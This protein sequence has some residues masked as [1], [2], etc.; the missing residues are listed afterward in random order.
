MKRLARSLVP[1]TT[2]FT[3]V[4]LMAVVAIIG[5]LAMI[6]IPNLANARKKGIE[7]Q[8]MENVASVSV[9]LDRR[10]TDGSFSYTDGAG[11]CP[12][13]ATY[14]GGATVPDLGVTIDGSYFEVDV[15]VADPNGDGLCEAYR[16]TA[17]GVVA[18]VAGE[19][20]SLDHARVKGGPWP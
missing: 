12:G 17:R 15:T 8:A 7:K 6:A 18:P 10:Y 9:A 14:G 20:L 16:V 1:G 2:G 13:T 4:E 5:I 3:L 19:T 11:A